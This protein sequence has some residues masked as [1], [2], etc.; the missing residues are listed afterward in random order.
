MED[1][2]L[3]KGKNGNIILIILLKKFIEGKSFYLLGANFGLYEDKQYYKKHK[4]EFKKYTD[5]CFREEY[6][7]K[8]FIDLPNVRMAADIVFG[9]ET[10][11]FKEKIW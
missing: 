1:H 8:K 2:Y 9:L 5:I 11:K 3:L 10:K 4:E 7:Y 6:S